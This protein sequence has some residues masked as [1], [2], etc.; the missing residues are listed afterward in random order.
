MKSGVRLGCIISP[1]LFLFSIDWIM[2]NTT[3]DKPRGIQWTLLSQLEDLDFANDIAVLSPN[4]KHLQEKL[5]RLNSFAKKTSLNINTVKTQTM[6][7]NSITTAPPITV[8]S[9]PLERVE[10]FT[11]FGYIMSSVN[12]DGKDNIGRL[13]K[14]Q[15][16]FAQSGSPNNTACEPKYTSTTA[17]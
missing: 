1:M 12:A 5:E 3:S 16:A 4:Q 13:G 10:D 17:T 8:N 6:F 11:Y 14:A 7:I 2:H 9:V 15:G